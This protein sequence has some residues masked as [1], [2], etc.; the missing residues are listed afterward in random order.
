M[1]STHI[2]VRIDEDIKAQAQDVFNDMGMDIT[3]AINIFFRQVVR[4][5]CFPFLPSADPF[6]ND[7][8]IEHLMNVKAD[9]AIGRNMVVHDLVED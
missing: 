2:H 9:A 7:S 6:Y 3:T 4:N 5:R 1:P 8:N